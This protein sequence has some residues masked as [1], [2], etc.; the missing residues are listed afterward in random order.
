MRYGLFIKLMLLFLVII[1]ASPF[2][3]RNKEG[4]PYASIGSISLPRISLPKISIPKLFSGKEKKSKYKSVGTEVLSPN[5]S[6]PN[7]DQEIIKIYTFK[8]KMGVSHYTN[9]KPDNKNYKI[10][11][12]PVDKEKSALTKIKDN[13]G[14]LS[15]RLNQKKTFQAQ[16]PSSN[17]SDLSLPIIYSQPTKAIKKAEEVRKK[18]ESNYKAQDLMMK[19]LDH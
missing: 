14:N 8:D 16:Q 15:Q 18:V 2:V 6:S 13:F 7:P 19:N 17:Q 4:K 5:I 1:C 3:L 9:K 10:L 12:M 11:Y